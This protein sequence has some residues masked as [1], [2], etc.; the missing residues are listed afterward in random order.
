MDSL[1][2][3]E[4][5]VSIQGEGLLTGTPSVFVRTSGCNLRCRWCD[6]PET[7]WSPEGEHRSLSDIVRE[8]RATGVKHA[9]L[10]GGEPL[11]DGAMLPL[12][13]A[14]RTQG[15]HLTVE[16]A[17]TYLPKAFEDGLFDLASISPKLAGSTPVGTRF[18]TVHDARR[19]RPDVIRRLMKGDY[20]LKF[21]PS[22]PDDL[23]EIDAI[24]NEVGAARERVL[25]MPEGV[26][27]PALDRAAEWLVD[28][29]VARGYR[30]CDRLHIRLFGHTRST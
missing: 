1:R 3:S 18:A 22:T 13:R 8:V 28:A 14:L 11:L 16:T 15:L 7:S 29:C 19:H 9:V 5:F 20:Q 21:V 6:T 17:A 23:D 24:V 26:D 12:A 10:T 27:V 4:I 2:I 30:F 25:L